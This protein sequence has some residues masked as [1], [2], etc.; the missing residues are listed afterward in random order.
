MPGNI[1]EDEPNAQVGDPDAVSDSWL[2]HGSAQAVVASLG[3]EP[4][5]EPFF[6]LIAP[7]CFEILLS[8]K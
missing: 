1:A 3:S 7:S 8:N 2:Q 6:A 5:S 4:D